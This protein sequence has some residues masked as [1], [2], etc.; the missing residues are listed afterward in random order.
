LQARAER[1]L[2]QR[3]VLLA[4][5]RAEAAGTEHLLLEQAHGVDFCS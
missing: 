2:A 4:N 1:K 5:V 3:C